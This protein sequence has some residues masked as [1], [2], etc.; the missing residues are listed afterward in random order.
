[1]LARERS[2]DQESNR[3]RKQVS[4]WYSQCDS[5]IMCG[6]AQNSVCPRCASCSKPITGVAVN[7]L[8][9]MVWVL[10]CGSYCRPLCA[11]SLTRMN[12]L[13]WHPECFNCARCGK[14]VGGQGFY[15][16]DSKPCCST[17]YTGGA[18]CAGC[19]SNIAGTYVNACGQKVCASVISLS[20]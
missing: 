20:T 6:V 18:V 5:I 13:Q 16:V 10:W 19:R 1:L 17:C 8:G 9:A 14:T 12:E 11:D 15:T 7:A 4:R 2:S 3:Q